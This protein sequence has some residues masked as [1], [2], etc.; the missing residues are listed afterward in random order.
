MASIRSVYIQY[1][2]NTLFRFYGYVYNTCILLVVTLLLNNISRMHCCVAKETIV[3]RT[4]P[5]LH[6]LSGWWNV[7]H[8][9]HLKADILPVRGVV[10]DE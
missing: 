4:H 7:T 3:T 9:Y 8:T 1:K 5:Q 6:S 10:L 2:G